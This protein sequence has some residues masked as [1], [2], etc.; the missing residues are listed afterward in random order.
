MF[1]ISYCYSI[2]TYYKNL[3]NYLI[4]IGFPSFVATYICIKRFRRFYYEKC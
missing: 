4:S 2:S 3:Y 1:D